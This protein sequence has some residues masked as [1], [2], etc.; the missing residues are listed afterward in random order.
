MPQSTSFEAAVTCLNPHGH[1]ISV[2]GSQ[3]WNWTVGAP[4]ERSLS[5]AARAR[6]AALRHYEQGRNISLTCRH[7]GISRP[8]FYRWQRRYTARGLAGLE[9][10]SHRPV[11]VALPTWSTTEVLAVRTMREQYPYMGKHKLQIMLARDGLV[12]SVSMVG[13]ILRR[14]QQSG[15][16]HDPPRL[17]RRRGRSQQRPHAVRKP[18]GYRIEVPGDLVQIDTL[19]V[20]VTAGTRMIHLSLVDMVGRWVAAE[21]R[22][23]KTAVTIRESLRRMEQRLPFP[24]R[25]IQID[26]GSEFKAEF[27]TYCQERGIRLFVLPPR[28]PKLNGMVERLQRTFRD[29]FYACVDLEPRVA[30]VATALRVYEDTYNTVRPHQA[31]GYRT[32]LQFLADQEV[33]A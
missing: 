16:L 7:F 13:R 31:L 14:L 4:H 29:E 10:R 26:G 19:D 5:P 2:T 24:I 6:L 3:A 33:R 22:S 21:V 8:A 27:E 30:A 23:G 1:Y 12:L 9:D 18:K 25:G 28:S 11:R 17:R 15:Q 32:P 20:A